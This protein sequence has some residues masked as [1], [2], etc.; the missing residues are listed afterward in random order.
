MSMEGIPA[1]FSV[2]KVSFIVDDK[3]VASETKKMGEVVTPDETPVEAEIV[4]KDNKDNKEKQKSE[5]DKLELEDDQYIEWDCDEE[6]PVYEDMEINGRIARYASVIA[7][8][9]V[10]ANKQS[11]FLAEGRF[12]DQD[13]MFVTQEASPNPLECYMITL[14]GDKTQY[15]RYQMPENTENVKIYVST[16]YGSEE[17]EAETE[18]FGRYLRF[19]VEGDVL[20]VRVE[21]VSEGIDTKYILAGSAAVAVICAAS[22]I[23]LIQRKRSAKKSPQK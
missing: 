19:P 21:A 3:V 9:Q 13:A 1:D 2:M 23:L 4:K 17:I 18:N 16:D 22:V 12:T 8:E 10:R 7:S 14:P 6:I 5:E 11:I 20:K 15:L